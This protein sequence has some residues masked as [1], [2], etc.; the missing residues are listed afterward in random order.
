[1]RVRSGFVVPLVLFLVGVVATVLMGPLVAPKGFRGSILLELDFYIGL[2]PGLALVLGWVVVRL[3]RQVR[4]A[5]P[6]S[7][8]IV[9]AIFY[10][11]MTATSY[12]YLVLTYQAEY[13]P[14]PLPD[15][16]G[17]SGLFG[18]L[19]GFGAALA[20]SLVGGL[21]LAAR[22]RLRASAIAPGLS[23]GIGGVFLGAFVFGNLF[24]TSVM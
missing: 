13:A 3:P 24:H 21:A 10:V 16:G 18:I 7:M 5:F 12:G 23:V 17:G 22:G 19:L 6:L 4:P 2:T 15:T 20:A 14:S 1:M 11:V 9:G 8:A